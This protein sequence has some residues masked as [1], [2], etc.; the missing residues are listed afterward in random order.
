MEIKAYNPVYA[1][2][3]PKPDRRRQNLSVEVDRRSG[4]DRRQIPRY[5]LASGQNLSDVDPNTQFVQQTDRRQQNISVDADRRAGGDRRQEARFVPLSFDTSN[6]PENT[7]FIGNILPENTP[8]LRDFRSSFD[9]NAASKLNQPVF[10]TF[11]YSG[12]TR[13]I[14][15]NLSQP[16]SVNQPIKEET[17]QNSKDFSLIPPSTLKK[18]TDYFETMTTI[19][20]IFEGSKSLKNLI[21]MAKKKKNNI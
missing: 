14:N 20:T 3:I 4:V 18:I 13:D 8:A 15:A 7:V 17:K 6:I 11:N 10:D 16:T 21:F 12:K 2:F 19:T 1:D 9:S 5:I